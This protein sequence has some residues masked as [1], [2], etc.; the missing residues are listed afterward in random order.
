MKKVLIYQSVGNC[1]GGVWFVYESLAT[2]LV[3]KGYDVC[4]LSFRENKGPIVIN[5]NQIFKMH[6]IN[7]NNIWEITRFTDIKKSIKQVNI[8]KAIRLALKKLKEEILFYKDKVKAKKF[9]KEYNPNYII[10]SHYQ[11]LDS[12]PKDYLKKTIFQQHTSVKVT[13][14][15]FP[16]T[17]K[18][19]DN[20]KEKIY[21]FIWL[22][23][24]SCK[25]AIQHGYKNSSY[26]YNPI[27]FKSSK[28]AKVTSNKKLITISR[29][30]S[31]EKRINLM[32]NITKDVLSNYPD[33][34]LELYGADKLNE[35]CMNI[36]N[37]SNQIKLMGM[38]NNVKEKLL[39][40]SIY[41][42][43]SSF[44][45]FPLS[46][47]EAYECGLPCITFDYGES[48]PEQIINKKTGYI[49]EFDDIEEFKEKLTKL[50][51]DMELLE[52]FS[53]EAKKHAK[54]FNIENITDSWIKEFE[55]ISLKER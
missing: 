27:K 36:I 18:T 52:V 10:C 19:L 46:I 5:T 11:L 2:S 30:N 4:I 26:I 8:I 21:R 16:K 48:C 22:T 34:T 49:I 1:N 7:K 35:E 29:L 54:K 41:L 44:E 28:K 45:G 50:M 31:P 40:A 47:T 20:Y 13:I 3:K 32:L 51:S 12:I 25:E 38:T 43:T 9:I 42:S 53:K 55:Q 17:I 15:D 6:T 14:K 39:N 37:S 24:N 23:E 33:W